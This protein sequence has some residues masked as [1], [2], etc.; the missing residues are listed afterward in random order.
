MVYLQFAAYWL[1]ES[2]GLFWFFVGKYFVED[3]GRGLH[4][5]QDGLDSPGEL[6]FF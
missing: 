5:R 4:F 6:V 3:F 2:C 1:S